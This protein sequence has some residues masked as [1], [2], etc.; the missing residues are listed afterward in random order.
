MIPDVN[1]AKQFIALATLTKFTTSETLSLRR[2]CNV[3]GYRALYGSETGKQLNKPTV[4][5]R[6]QYEQCNI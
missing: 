6:W 5:D 1:E 3:T 2:M 4:S